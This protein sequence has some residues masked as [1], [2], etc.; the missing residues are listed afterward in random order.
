ML[1]VAYISHMYPSAVR[2]TYG[3]FIHDH[4]KAVQQSGVE[5]RVI[6]PTPWTPP[7][8]SRLR[9]KWSQYAAF[10]GKTEQFAGVE[11]FRPAYFAP[12]RPLQHLGAWGMAA[13]LQRHWRQGGADLACDLIHAHAITPDGFAACQLARRLGRPVICSAR[14]SEVHQTP[15]ESAV[16]RRLTR[17]TLQHCDAAIAVSG[18]LAQ[19]AA[20]LAEGRV[21][22]RVIYNGVAEDF[23]T[24]T[25][26]SA[27]R[28]QL[29]LPEA[30][31]IILFVG[32]CEMDKGAGELLEAFAAIAAQFPAAQLVLAGDGGARP[33][34]ERRTRSKNWGT[35][36]RFAG[37]VGRAQI[38]S[39]FRAAD[40]FVLPSYG[41][42]MPNALLEAMAAGVP[43][44]ATRVGGIPEAI[45]DGV[46]GLLIPAQSGSAVASAVHRLLDSPA[47]AAQL[48]AAAQGTIR[49]RFTWSANAQS[50]LQIYAEVLRD[51]YSQK[52]AN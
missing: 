4:V 15:R 23:Q 10:A 34:L 36:V 6:V 24:V 18:A 52:H 39:Y 29:G 50:H 43:C 44:V 12:P 35:R 19:N 33:E 40:V 27:A 9:R 42:G 21:Q 7:G 17:W 37:L 41:E 48:G 16:V 14:G 49:R 11:V 47:F 25:G 20:D 31:Q 45:E 8:L 2:P 1:K 28:R 38:G 13:S 51:F 3:Q 32:R 46:N 30:A 22:P 5:V 26:R